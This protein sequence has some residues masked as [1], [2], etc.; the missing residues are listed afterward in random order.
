[1]VQTTSHIFSGKVDIAS[2]LKVGSSRLFV[3]T[4]NNRVGI[5]ESDPDASLHVTGNAYI[6]T[7]VGI[8]S[9]I[10]LEGATGNVTVSGNVH[11]TGVKVNGINVALDPDLSDNASR[12]SVL[13]TDATSNHNRIVA[14]EELN[15]DDI[16][17]DM[18]SN[19][20]RI[21]DM[22]T[23][24]TVQS[25]LISAITLDMTSNAGRI[26]DMFA[27]NTVQRNLIS[28]ITIDMTS[29]AG[30]IDDLLTANTVQRNL[31][32][33]ITID[34]T[35]NAGR[36]DDLLTANT[37]QR[38]LITD[39]TDDMTSNAGRIDLII[40]DMTSNAGRI[41][42]MFAANTVQSGLITDITLDMTSN[43]GRID[44]LDTRIGNLETANNVQESLIN[45]LITSNADIWSNLADNVTRITVLEDDMASNAGRITNL[46][47]SNVDIWSNLAANVI[48]ITNLETANTV[49][50]DLIT[51]I[52]GDMTS[53][54]GRIDVIISDV[55]SNAL[56]LN[57]MFAAN[58]VQG[59]L[60]TAITTDMTSNAGR[61]DDLFAANTVQGG[62]I[63]DITTDMTSNAGRIDDLFTANT[64]Q[65]GL[66][67][68]IT[69][70]MTSNAG[71]IDD[72]FAANTVQGGLITDIT[73]DMTSNAGRI[74]DLFAANT[75]QSGLITDITT[76]MA[77]NAAR[78][79]YITTVA[80]TT[81]I[82]SNLEVTGNIFMRGDRFVVESETKLINDA[83]IGIANNN[84]LSTTDVGVVMQRPDANV[85]LIHH[86]SGSGS[87]PDQFTMGY[88]QSTLTDGDITTDEANIFTLNVL[89]NVTAQN[90]I[91]STTSTVSNVTTMGTTKTFVVTMSSASGGNK[92]YIDGYLQASLELH[93]HQTYIFDLSSS[94]LSGHPF[95]FDSSNSND[96]TT[97]SDPYYTT[98]ITS[99]GVY[100]STEKRT[101]VVPAGAPT[102][103]YYYCTAHTGMGATISIS[104]TAELIVSGRVVASGNVEASAF[105]GDGT[106]LTGVALSADMTSNVDRIEV[107][108]TSNVDIWSNL[109]SNVDRIEA[110][111]TSNVNIWSNLASNVDRIEALE[112]SNVNIWSNLASN[113][114]RIEALE[115]S[116]VN[117]WSNLASNVDRIE[118]LETSNVNIWSN[119]ASNVVRIVALENNGI[120]SNSSGINSIIQGDI[121]Y[122]SADSTLQ[123]LAV[124]ASGEVLK[125]VGGVPA[126]ATESGGA[127]GVLVSNSVGITT[128]FTQGDIIY[129]SADNTLSKLALGSSGQVLKSDGTDVVWG[130]DGGGGSTVWLTNG[131]KIHYDADN[132][133]IGTSTPAFKLDVHGTANV[134]ALTA[135]TL[136]VG[137]ADVA[138]DADMTAN[139]VRVDAL[140]TGTTGQLIYGTGTDTLGKLD[141]GTTGH[142]LKVAGGVPK[143]EAESGG[144]GGGGQWTGTSEI[145]FEG[146][147]GIS[148]TD[149]D[150]DLSVGS[151]FI[152]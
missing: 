101:F 108:E 16:R 72:L 51:D 105:I 114:D 122:A 89:G 116:N 11:A 124:G 81:F 109:A 21:D 128:G 30:R 136:S 121:V 41:D 111:E 150:H 53:N 90:N 71:R 152:Y 60:I 97:N 73:T 104:P 12:I 110:L 63:T 88:T 37:V 48:R 13:E 23:A 100:G 145:Y 62:L 142:V 19:A 47:T 94:T 82:A 45:T 102:T 125:V 46:M 103:L 115:T 14:L 133:G 61:I 28:A 54:A 77:S 1:M 113:V 137:G 117:I 123:T 78:V 141:I 120:I 31:I 66:I 59:G 119:L 83:V 15:I 58:T 56:R 86:G 33:A 87:Y 74:D 27:A 147:V 34:M 8:G 93:Q 95:V 42:D 132:V 130:T 148:N 75:V 139:A 29:N 135:T 9:T 91:T 7:N 106:K 85:A 69:T 6:E 80:D 98:G 129:A 146:N 22:F 55:L 57:Q 2:N 140:Y 107:L 67:T 24:N 151:N 92:Y 50:R 39:I 127:A 64:V 79:Q 10:N 52:T 4:E 26:N 20:G 49:Q 40:T 149:P 96:G 143:W 18:T 3:D 126:W 43:S 68:D 35:S 134:G 36:I 118:A 112:T 17:T 70:D 65:G 144:G 25:G 32:S 84:T 76:D 44:G 99:T 38:D 5:N 131:N 138:L